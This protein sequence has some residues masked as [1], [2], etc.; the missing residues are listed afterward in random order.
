[1][2]KMRRRTIKSL[3]EQME[4]IKSEFENLFDEEQDAYYNMPESL[5]YSE[6]GETMSEGI[7]VL[8]DTYDTIGDIIDTLYDNFNLY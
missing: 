2:N 3:V 1:M 8:S 7:E 5:Q 4:A 6:R